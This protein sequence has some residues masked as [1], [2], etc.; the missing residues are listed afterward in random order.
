MLG[1]V[2]KP[3]VLITI[4]VFLIG[5]LGFSLYLGSAQDDSLII[6]AIAV[7]DKP[8]ALALSID[9][10][11]AYVANGD[12]GSI[13]ILDLTE[14]N[15]I[16]EIEVGRDPNSIALTPDGQKAYVS[17]TG[18][19]D[20]SVINLATQLNSESDIRVTLFPYEIA[21]A[22]NGKIA[23][24]VNRRANLVSI[25][26]IETDQNIGFIRTGQNPVRIAINSEGTVG[27]VV[28]FVSKNISVL[29]LV[30]RNV[31]DTFSIPGGPFAINE[32]PFDIT[33]SPDNSMLLL[34]YIGEE[35]S[36][37]VVLNTSDGT[38]IA[39]IPVGIEPTDIEFTS[40]GRYAF[41][42]N[43]DSNSVS[44]VDLDSM[45]NLGLDFEVGAR[46]F[47]IELSPDE[48]RAYV[49]SADDDTVWVI[50]L[51]KIAFPED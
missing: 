43:I 36:E 1:A 35:T 6:D 2:P 15:Q 4:L 22:P 14:N 51:T 32:G 49:A 10:L 17:N 45:S 42:V 3:L 48:T 39:S 44:I 38:H 50:D 26:D 9:G 47:D 25:I 29:D 12:G 23:Y 5:S 11:F 7:G 41:V 40:N 18:D 34:G 13:S 16:A 24:V 28:N 21:I 8:V 46:P 37:L 33:I 27:Y 30:D 31:V 19:N 20:V